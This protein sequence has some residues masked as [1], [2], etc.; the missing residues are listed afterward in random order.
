[1]LAA[2]IGYKDKRA[3]AA[4][5]EN[6][7]QVESADDVDLLAARIGYK[8]L[9]RAYSAVAENPAQVESAE[10][11]DLLAARIGYKDKRAYSAVAENPA[12]VES[13]ED[14]DLLAARIG[15][16]YTTI[17]CHFAYI[18]QVTSPCDYQLGRWT[19]VRT[20]GNSDMDDCEHSWY[21]AIM[22]Q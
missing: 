6:P 9:K 5:A 8:V 14:V 4:V 7:T 3:Y 22:G 16:S 19:Q 10:D 17:I 15:T 2:R 13:A 12:Q 20:S 21:M 1:M 18:S 11:V